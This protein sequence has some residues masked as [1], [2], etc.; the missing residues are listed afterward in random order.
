MVDG[1]SFISPEITPFHQYKF[2][3]CQK[4]IQQSLQHRMIAF[5]R[6][7][8]FTVSQFAQKVELLGFA[9]LAKRIHT[10]WS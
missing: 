8:T 9:K 10:Y 2:A 6:S 4:T 7:I 5:P 3:G 1:Y